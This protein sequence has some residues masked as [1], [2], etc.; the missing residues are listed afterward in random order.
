MQFC[1]VIR[2]FSI[3]RDGEILLSVARGHIRL[4]ITSRFIK[5]TTVLSS[6]SVDIYRLSA[7]NSKLNAF[8]MIRKGSLSISAAKGHLGPEMTSPIGSSTPSLHSRQLEFFVYCLPFEVIRHF[9]FA[10]ISHTG[11]KCG[12]I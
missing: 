3:V 7:I 8:S 5:A 2:T 11:Q 9:L 1:K 4:E 6:R 10:K 12:G